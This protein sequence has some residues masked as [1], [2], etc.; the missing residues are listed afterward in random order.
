MIQIIETLENIESDCAVLHVLTNEVAYVLA[1]R[2]VDVIVA[3]TLVDIASKFVGELN[4]EAA[5][6]RAYLGSY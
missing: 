4:V 5:A 2:R 1:R 3:R 6:H